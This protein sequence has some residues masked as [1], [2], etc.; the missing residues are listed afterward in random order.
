MK[1]LI[2]YFP[3]IQCYMTSQD[4]FL[5]IFLFIFFRL[6]TR[7]TA[8]MKVL[9]LPLSLL[10]VIVSADKCTEKCA[11]CETVERSECIA[12]MEKD[13]ECG[14]CDVCSRYFIHIFMHY[15]VY[16]LCV[17]HHY[18]IRYVSLMSYNKQKSMIVHYCQTINR[19]H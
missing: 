7:N 15:L 19:C 12:G 10:V 11:K 9:L 4:C 18:C 16:Y 8:I 5:S 2:L 14:C 3:S 1:L 13:P 17:L 6:G